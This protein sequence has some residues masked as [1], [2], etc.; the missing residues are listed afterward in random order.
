[1]GD[2]VSW[3]VEL[4]VN[5]GEL[6]NFRALTAEMVESTR[7][8]GGVLIYERFI[9]DDGKAVHVYERYANS[10]AALAHLRAFGKEFRARFVGMVDRKQFTVY[11]TPSE[12]LKGM[13]DGFGA[14]YL[15]RFGGFSLME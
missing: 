2:E 9:S 5:P 10:A 7:V 11:G 6:A 15:R 13:L 8:E 4:S 3:H 1:M 14:T 12:E